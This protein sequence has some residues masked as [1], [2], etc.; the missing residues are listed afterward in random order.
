MSTTTT[1]YL[2]RGID[3]RIWQRAR[4]RAQQDNVSIRFLLLK[5]LEQYGKKEEGLNVVLASREAD[6]Q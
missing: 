1:A 2:L 6:V 3:T 5:F 4:K